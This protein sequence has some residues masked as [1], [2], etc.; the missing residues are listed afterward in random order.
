MEPVRMQPA[1]QP[2]VLQCIGFGVMHNVCMQAK[3]RL[4]L[5]LPAHPPTCT[6][7]CTAAAVTAWLPSFPSFPAVCGC[8]ARVGL[9]IMR[10]SCR[11]EWPA[12]QATHARG[13]I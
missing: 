2:G 1:S 3:H 11:R 6:P 8:L 9:Q 10:A 12:S 4:P 5:C 7:T 13:S